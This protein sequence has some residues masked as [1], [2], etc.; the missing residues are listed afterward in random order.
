MGDMYDG[1]NAVETLAS[2]TQDGIKGSRY[3]DTHYKM[4]EIREK[5][6]GNVP[7]PI[8]LHEQMGKFDGQVVFI[9]HPNRDISA[10]QWSSSSFQW[11]NIGRYSH[12]RGKVEGSLASD[13]LEGID[14]PHNTLAYFKLAA[15]NRQS[16]IVENGRPKDHN[17]TADPTSHVGMEV[18][19]STQT[20]TTASIGSFRVAANRQ[21]EAVSLSLI[22]Y[23]PL[24]KDV[25][26]DPFVAAANASISRFARDTSMQGNLAGQAGSLDLTYRFPPKMFAASRPIDRADTLRPKGVGRR[27][28]DCLSAPI[29][30]EVAFDEEAVTQRSVALANSKR[31]HSP[32]SAPPEPIHGGSQHQGN[33][34]E[35]QSALTMRNSFAQGTLNLNTTPLYAEPTRS[36]APLT[37]LASN[38]SGAA[39]SCAKAMTVATD[40]IASE[41]TASTV[42]STAVGLHY[43][44]P[45]S[46]RRTQH[47]EIA[48]GLNQQAPTPQTFKGPFFTDTKPTTHDPTVALSVRIGEEEKLVNWFRDGHRPARQREYT[49]SLIAAATTTT[50]TRQFGAIGEACAKKQGGPYANTG[51]FVRLYENLSEYV[52]EYCNGSSRSYFTQ[53]WKPATPQTR[54]LGFGNNTSY[55][56]KAG[57]Q[58][59]WP[60]GVFLRPS[61][62]MWG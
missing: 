6:F 23:R 11:M 32:L 43:S 29:L 39:V 41:S 14:E 31:L 13:R 19:P 33:V 16:L 58:S 25:L 21:S 38:L 55:F 60:R 34:D 47:Y 2:I 18:V 28:L 40:S 4:V 17:T 15:Q 22:P 35:Q 61:E 24:T 5:L 54:D 3:S 46:L 36:A 20:C 9:G 30:H 44:D 12:S 42:N 56:S 57:I 27:T 62:R 10:H 53:H 51:P 26:E 52:E 59:S 49:K 1:A 45:D 50:K 7:D 48:N 37:H 8:R